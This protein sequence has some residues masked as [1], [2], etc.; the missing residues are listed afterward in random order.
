MPELTVCLDTED[1]W[2][3]GKRLILAD[4]PTVLLSKLVSAHGGT[5][6]MERLCACWSFDSEVFDDRH[7]VMT[8]VCRLKK[9]LGKESIVKRPGVGYFLNLKVNYIKPEDIPNLIT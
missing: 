7:C 6:S 5:V 1:F 4:R 8:V 2:L 9:I 3:D